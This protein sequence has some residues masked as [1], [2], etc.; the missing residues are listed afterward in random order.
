MKPKPYAVGAGTVPSASW[1]T[2]RTATPSSWSRPGPGSGWRH[3]H[4]NWQWVSSSAWCNASRCRSPSPSP[5]WPT[6][7]RSG[8]ASSPSKWEQAGRPFEPELVDRALGLL[9]E[10]APTQG[11]SVLLHQDLHSDNVLAAQREPWLAIDPKPLAGEV[12]FAVAPLCRDYT[13]GHS[14]TRGAPPAGPVLRRA[15]P[16]P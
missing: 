13:L 1:P 12:E 4:P 6:K 15:R 16:R 3:P 14:P 8:E 2:I 7:P 9:G 11:P 10:L 5:R